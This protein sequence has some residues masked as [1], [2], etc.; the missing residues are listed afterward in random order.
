MQLK[1]IIFDYGGVL[2][3][4]PPESQVRELAA[5]CRLEYEQFLEGYWSLRASYDRG[6]IDVGQYWTGIGRPFG[7]MYTGGEIARFSRADVMFWVHIDPPMLDWAAR[8]RAAGIPTGLL[9][10]LPRDLGEYFR[11]ETDLLENFDRHTFSYELNVAK[12]EPGIYR[13]AVDALG[14]EPG[15]ALFIDDRAENVEG[16]KRFGMP[17]L[18]FVSPRQLALDLDRLETLN[19][20]RLPFGTPPV[21]LE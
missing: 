19:G 1:A 5:A 13:F 21:L 20:C 2:C 10:N 8:V 17:A 9:S 16:A 3:T 6:D 7:R 12:P 18:Q 15:E 4:P 11:R 14:V